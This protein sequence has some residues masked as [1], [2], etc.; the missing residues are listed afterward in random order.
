MTIRI[1]V[2]QFPGANCDLD[3]VHVLNDVMGIETTSMAQSF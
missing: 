1:A 2:I 3:A